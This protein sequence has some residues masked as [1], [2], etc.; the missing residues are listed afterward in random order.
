MGT[1]RDFSLCDGDILGDND[2]MNSSAESGHRGFRARRVRPLPRWR[3][4]VYSHLAAIVSL[5]CLV[6]GVSCTGDPGAKVIA[7]YRGG[8][9][10]SAEYDGFLRSEGREP[11]DQVDIGAVRQIAIMKTFAAAAEE[12]GADQDLAPKLDEIRRVKLSNA[13]EKH[14]G[15]EVTVSQAEV[16]A[17][18][19]DYP[20]AFVKA[21]KLLLYNIFKSAPTGGTATATIRTTMEDI[22]RQ[23]ETGIDFSELAR[24]ESESQTRFDGGRIGFVEPNQLAPPIA[25][26]AKGLI[27]GQ[28]SEVI[29]HPG[30]FTI[31]KCQSIRESTRPS[32]EE[33]REKIRI[34]LRRQVVKRN[35]SDY[36]KGLLDEAQPEYDLSVVRAE[37]N[38]EA[39][40]VRFSGRWL[41]VGEVRTVAA[42]RGS[43]RSLENYSN[44]QLQALIQDHLLQRLCADRAVSLGL[45]SADIENKLRWRRLVLL[46]E[47]EGEFLARQQVAPIEQD[48][49]VA[50][51]EANRSNFEQPKQWKVAVIR[52]GVP[53]TGQIVDRLAD[54]G[55]VL[56]RIRRG[57]ISFGDAARSVSDHP[58]ALRGGE[59]G[60]LRDAQVASLGPR[61]LPLVK[62]LGPGETSEIVR[63]ED[64]LW[65]FEL[66]DSRESRLLD[67]S[68]AEAEVRAALEKQRMKSAIREVR[69]RFI[70]EAEVVLVADGEGCPEQSD[71]QDVG[72]S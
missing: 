39:A 18:R 3:R 22:H 11:S 67:F 57:E 40:I 30:G 69:S 20:E 35:W 59:L 44:E 13:L 25:A 50:V 66:L 68:E 56:E 2:R 32:E 52:F 29:E 61:V 41:T 46:G 49:V 16:E 72:H 8:S 62:E 38:E 4:Q 23:L 1:L 37:D 10:S 36:L 12:R 24:R 5:G 19:R 63:F 17:I 28:V 7:C 34:N 58:S 70:R 15:A 48:E 54:A 64:G 51:F 9:I 43:T 65:I 42:A 53:E 26:V 55:S 60:W 71:V 21:R 47:M 33:V 14:V 31:L 6:G 27:E 45:Q